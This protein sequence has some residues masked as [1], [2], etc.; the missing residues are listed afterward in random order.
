MV[1]RYWD[2][3]KGQVND[4]FLNL[5]EIHDSTAKGLFDSIKSILDKY[6]IPYRNIIGF[7]AD[8]ASVMM[9]NL[10]GVQSLFKE[11]N[12][13]IVVIGCTSHSLHLC[14]SQ[15]AKKLPNTIE[16]FTR[17]IYSYFAHSSKRIE[18]L[19]NCQIFATKKPKKM[20]YPSQV[21]WLSL[22]VSL[23]I[24]PQMQLDVLTF[25]KF[26]CS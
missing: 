25:G 7:S 21:R 26:F 23:L 8:N 14:A 2:P 17:D 9:G 19:K 3:E 16:Q 15:A 11:L 5:V 4:R 6:Q 10:N 24:I 1:A 12:P 22:R 13:H 20:L 18:E